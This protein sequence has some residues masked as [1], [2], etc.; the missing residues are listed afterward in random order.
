MPSTISLIRLQGHFSDFVKKN[1]LLFGSLIES[2][3][4][5]MKDGTAD[6]LE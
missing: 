3:D 6:D 2:A 4:D 5:L 1:F